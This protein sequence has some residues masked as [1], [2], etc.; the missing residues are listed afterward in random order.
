MLKR[1]KSFF[2]MEEPYSGGSNEAW[3]AFIKNW[4]R[5]N[6]YPRKNQ[7]EDL[8]S[9]LIREIDKLTDNLDNVRSLLCRIRRE[10]YS[11]VN[12]NENGGNKSD[13]S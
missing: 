8:E 12:N 9:K 4:A 6:G 3:I 11:N 1:I 5:E 2:G 10:K 13:L 7:D